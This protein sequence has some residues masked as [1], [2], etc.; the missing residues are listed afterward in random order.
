MVFLEWSIKVACSQAFWF[1]FRTFRNGGARRMDIK[2]R[3]TLFTKYADTI[4]LRRSCEFAKCFLACVVMFFQ[5]KV[6]P[7]LNQ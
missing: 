3:G 5:G 6:C 1:L 7:G 4:F 2:P